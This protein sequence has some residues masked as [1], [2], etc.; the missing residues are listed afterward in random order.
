MQFSMLFSLSGAPQGQ[1]HKPRTAVW[2]PGHPV[3]VN[4][5][6]V[7]ARNS[8]GERCLFRQGFLGLATFVHEQPCEQLGAVLGA[9]VP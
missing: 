1:L 4:L 6:E 7:G 3:I 9:R 2:H 8:A 5:P